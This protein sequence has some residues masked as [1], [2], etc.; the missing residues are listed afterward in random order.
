[1]VPV[2]NNHIRV[3]ELPRLVIVPISEIVFHEDYNEERVRTLTESM[4]RGNVLKNPP[5][6]ASHN[7]PGSYIL[8]DGANRITALKSLEISDVVVQLIEL[9]D[10]GLVI[11]SWHHAVEGFEKGKFLD[12]IAGFPE[13][14]VTPVTLEK[15]ENRLNET[16]CHIQFFDGSM[17]EVSAKGDIFS[18][19]ARLHELTSIY[20]GSQYMDRVSYTNLEH[21][22][23][24]YS[25]FSCLMVFPE[26][27]KEELLRITSANLKIPSGLTRITLPK[28]AL[29]LNVPLDIL[30]FQVS[31]DQKNHWLQ[32]RIND[33]IKD[34]SIRFYRE[35]TF[36]FDE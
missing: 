11:L 34:K 17:F 22:K 18:R 5:V 9:D 20:K 27:T 21:L 31:G 14:S 12:L 7:V 10:P 1:M 33:Q 26:F 16:I 8:L 32:N 4:R 35:P 23:H 13:F 28:R 15:F 6:A 29:R 19:V 3:G 25:R 30:R 24:N 2:N 36:L